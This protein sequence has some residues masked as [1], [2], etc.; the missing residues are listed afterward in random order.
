MRF[1]MMRAENFVVLR[2]KPI[3]VCLALINICN[4]VNSLHVHVHVFKIL[5]SIN[6][7]FINF[8]ANWKMK[9]V[10]LATI[11]KLASGKY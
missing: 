7:V 2:R 1:M 11:Y 4:A 8:K 3:E 9:T 5:F 10:Q 6:I